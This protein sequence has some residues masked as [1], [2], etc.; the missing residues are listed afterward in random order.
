MTPISA[1]METNSSLAPSGS[2]PPFPKASPASRYSGMGES[3]KRPAARPSRP[4]PRR[5]E[6]NSI[7]NTAEC[8]GSLPPEDR[9]GGVDALARTDDD[10]D[11]TAREPEVRRRGG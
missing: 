1:P 7:S 10:H 5:M 4:R 8:T 11:V 9:R 6:P 2:R 3:R